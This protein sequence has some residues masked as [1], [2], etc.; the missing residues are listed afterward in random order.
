MANRQENPSIVT[1]KSKKWPAAAAAAVL[2]VGGGAT[3]IANGGDVA[4]VRPAPAVANVGNIPQ[5]TVPTTINAAPSETR[6]DA[7]FEGADSSFFERTGNIGEAILGGK[8][9]GEPL[10]FN[11]DPHANSEDSGVGHLVGAVGSLTNEAT[12]S[13]NSWDAEV[14]PT[15]I[16][17]ASIGEPTSTKP[18]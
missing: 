13:K 2:A 18:N 1:K 15:T 16:P 11:S 14:P 4:P 8:M 3:V 12:G 6:P 10:A 5:T 7:I 17:Q 9:D